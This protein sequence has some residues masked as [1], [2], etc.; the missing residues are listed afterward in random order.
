M[1][2][3]RLFLPAD[4]R[5]QEWLLLRIIQQMPL[6]APEPTVERFLAVDNVRVQLRCARVDSDIVLKSCVAE[7]CLHILCA[8]MDDCVRMCPDHTIYYALYSMIDFL[9]RKS[10]PLS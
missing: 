3:R 1:H 9:H 10:S 5:P 6:R 4:W 8:R 2:N 7:I